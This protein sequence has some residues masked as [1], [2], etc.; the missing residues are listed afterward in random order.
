MGAG[1]GLILVP[2]M[3][4]QIDDVR[5]TDRIC[6]DNPGNGGES[7]YDELVTV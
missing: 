2:V 3:Y 5:Y 4:A 7:F 6:H 1:E